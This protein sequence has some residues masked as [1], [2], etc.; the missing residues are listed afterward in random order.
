[1]WLRPQGYAVF[2][3]RETGKKTE[4]D[5]S[6]CSHCQRLTHITPGT[7]PEDCGGFCGGSADT[8]IAIREDNI[9]ISSW[10]I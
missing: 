10:R 1:M 8:N 4:F 6:Q 2:T 5:T 9:F 3:D 7:R